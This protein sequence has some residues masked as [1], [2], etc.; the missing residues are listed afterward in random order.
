MLLNQIAGE[1][2]PALAK[3]QGRYQQGFWVSGSGQRKLGVDLRFRIDLAVRASRAAGLGAGAQRFVHDLLD[4]A[5]APAALGAA[6]QTSIDLPRRA[7]RHLSRTHG[8]AHVVVGEDVTGTDNHGIR[9]TRRV[10][11]LNK[12]RPEPDAKEKNVFSS[13]SKL[14]INGITNWNE[15]KEMPAEQGCDGVNLRNLSNRRR[16]FSVRLITIAK[17]IAAVARVS[18]IAQSSP[19][20][21]AAQ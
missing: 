13:D 9:D 8:V 12:V 2:N 21:G 6:T 1:S 16:R 20:N 7:W 15:S 5:G 10:R 11:S 17:M 14:S 3:R 4:G 19:E 18:R